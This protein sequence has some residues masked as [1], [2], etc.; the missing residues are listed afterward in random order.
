MSPDFWY[1]FWQQTGLEQCKR[2]EI[3]VRTFSNAFCLILCRNDVKPR[4]K[5]RPRTASKQ[6]AS[7]DGPPPDVGQPGRPKMSQVIGMLPRAAP[8]A[9][10]D[11][12][13]SSI[14]LVR[15]AAARAQSTGGD[16]GHSAMS[17]G[18]QEHVYGPGLSYL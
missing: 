4:K 11:G 14:D 2:H 3:L 16:T 1:I 17:A 15:T 18:Q 12:D 6:A 8:R 5:T 13:Y 10:S 7:Q 9:T